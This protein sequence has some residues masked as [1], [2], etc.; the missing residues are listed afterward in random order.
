[1]TF[2]ELTEFLDNLGWPHQAMTDSVAKSLYSGSFGPTKVLFHV[3]PAGLRIAINP[4]LEKPSETGAWGKSVAQ[5]VKKLNQESANIRIGLDS[6]GDIYVKLD[7]P[8][9]QL[10]FDQFVYV[11]VNFCQ[12]SDQLTVPVLQAQAYDHQTAV[13]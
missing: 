13:A 5:L 7:L 6:E 10:S 9:Q 3:N 2:N 11:L 12:V 4:V 8:K 1:M